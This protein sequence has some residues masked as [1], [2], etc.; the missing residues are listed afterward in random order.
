MRARPSGRLAQKVA[1]VTISTSVANADGWTWTG[2]SCTHRVAP[3]AL[4][5]MPLNMA[6]RARIIATYSTA[7]ACSSQR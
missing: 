3:S 2:P 6:S 5:P 4:D 1:T 7:L